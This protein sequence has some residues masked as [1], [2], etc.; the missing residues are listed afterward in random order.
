MILGTEH[1]TIIDPDRAK[2]E[3]VAATLCARFGES[4]VVTAADPVAAMAEADGLIN[5]SPIGMDKYPGLP[6]PASLLRPELWVAEI[7]YFPLQTGLLQVAQAVGC[8]TLDGGGM[9]VFQAAGAFALF[10]GHTADA[11]RM[12]AHFRTLIKSAA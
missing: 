12:T 4:R 6:L 1:L 8:R 3:T 5:A 2:A 7:I 10:T 11:D 9:A